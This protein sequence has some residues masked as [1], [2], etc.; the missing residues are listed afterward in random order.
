MTV[1]LVGTDP[2]KTAA[3]LRE[4]GEAI[5]QEQRSQ[6]ADRLAQARLLLAAEM[7][8]ARGRSKLLQDTIGR[9][10]AGSAHARP[11]EAIERRTQ[12]AALRIEA[13]SVLDARLVVLE[14]RASEVAFTEA[15]EVGDLGLQLQLV[16]ESL[17]ALAPPSLPSTWPVAASWSS[18]SWLFSRY[19]WPGCST[20]GS[21]RPRIS[22]RAACPASARWS[23]SPGDDAGSYRSRVP[24]GS[25]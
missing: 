9:L 20:T 23:D 3:T 17:V 12:A 11:I 19:R 14:R 1:S 22:R 8:K 2:E 5:L 13:G 16:D 24:A 10:Q 15:A 21:T 4:V 6:R 25:A 18:W 7:L